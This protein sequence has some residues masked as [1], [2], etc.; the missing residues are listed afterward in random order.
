MQ[1]DPFYHGRSGLIDTL[2]WLKRKISGQYPHPGSYERYEGQDSMTPQQASGHQSTQNFDRTRAGYRPGPGSYSQRNASFGKTVGQLAVAAIVAAVPISFYLTKPDDMGT[3]LNSAGSGN[4]RSAKS[5]G[6]NGASPAAQVMGASEPLSAVMDDTAVEHAAKHT[7]QNYV[8]PM[9]PDVID[10]DPNSICPI[11]GMDLVPLEV[12]G[13]AGVVKL[14]PTVINSLGVRTSK[15]KRRTLYRRVDSVGYINVNETNLRSINLRTDGWVEHLVVKTEGERVVKG[16]LLLEVY[17]PKLVNAQE[18]YRQAKQHSNTD[19]LSASRE[20]LRSLGVSDEQIDTLDQTGVVEN[21]V[22]IYAPQS[23]IV[24]KLTVREGA[25]VKPSQNII[26]LVD[27]SSVWLMVDVF[28]RQAD[29]VK[30]GQRAEATLP[31]MPGKSWEGN[32]EYV[33]PSLDASTRSLKVRL[34]FDNMDEALKPNMYADVTI[35]AKPKKATL[36]IPR[37]ALIR[38]GKEKRVIVALGEGKFIPMPVSVG[39]EAGGNVEILKGLNE[40]DEV[41]VSSQF[42]IDSE[43]SMKASL[44]RM[45]G[46]G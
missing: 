6:S 36:A 13:E 34:R 2:R 12:G 29:W 27:L 15:V 44:A 41:V 40:G 16:Q 32:V 26:N 28:E 39:L 1:T 30:V 25:Y 17:S 45:A 11:C 46:G 22:K 7:K 37:E 42:L 43:S 8:C 20:R 24:S 21:L 4:A 31:F 18:E 5:F 9:H 38:T 23:G 19:L 35:Y 3:V 33:Y 10:T 14:T